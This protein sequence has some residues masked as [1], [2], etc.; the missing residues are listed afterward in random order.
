MSVS[1]TNVD[2]I[3]RHRQEGFTLIE[4]MIVV[5]IIGIL[6]TI[7]MPAYNGYIRQSKVTAVIEHMT[8]AVRVVKSENAKINA[9][10]NGNDVVAELNEGNRLAVG[11]PANPAFAAGPVALAGQV[12]IDGLDGAGRPMPGAAITITGTPAPGTVA[13]DYTSPLVL[14]VN[15]E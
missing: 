8:N 13:G 15:L 7:A 14:N 12:A 11:D 5:A 6:A 4:L 2:G 10:A 9:G 3:T 1:T